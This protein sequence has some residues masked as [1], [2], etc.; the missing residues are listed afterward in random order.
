MTDP[1]PPRAA[2]R[3]VQAPTGAALHCRN[4]QIEAAWRMLQN[5]LDPAVAE[6]PDALVV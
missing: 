2:P 1:S 6:N 5:N 4:W 3:R